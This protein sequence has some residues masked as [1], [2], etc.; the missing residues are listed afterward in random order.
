MGK[1][2][3]G[4]QVKRIVNTY[5]KCGCHCGWYNPKM[6]QLT[7]YKQEPTKEAKLD[8]QNDGFRRRKTK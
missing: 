6:Y 5:N 7:W 4:I 3:T 1:L 8:L 2:D